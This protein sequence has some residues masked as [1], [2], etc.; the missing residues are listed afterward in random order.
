MK[1]SNSSVSPLASAKIDLFNI[2]HLCHSHIL[3][4]QHLDQAIKLITQV[5]CQCEPMTHYLNIPY[6]EFIPFATQV[7]EK[8][9]REGFSMGLTVCN[10][11]IACTIIEDM[12]DPF[13]S[14]IDI[15]TQFKSIF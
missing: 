14:T 9:I 7:V 10:K 15:S 6:N 12:A 4:N 8:A 13:S 2:N 1:E 5:F 3:Q 11:L